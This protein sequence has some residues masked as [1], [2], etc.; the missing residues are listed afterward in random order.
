MQ[1]NVERVNFV[2]V[3][4]QSLALWTVTAN[5]SPA[6]LLLPSGFQACFVANWN[7]RRVHLFSAVWGY[8]TLADY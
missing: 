6:T 2:G 4:F 8:A 5:K 7:H 1:R 3:G